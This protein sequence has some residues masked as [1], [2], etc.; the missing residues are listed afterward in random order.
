M[1]DRRANG[2]EWT[3][4][5]RHS[6]GLAWRAVLIDRESLGE[7]LGLSDQALDLISVRHS[8]RAKRL[9]FK[10]SVRGGFELVLPRRY[11]DDW[12]LEA[13]AKR[14]SMV[15]RRLSEIKADRSRLLPQWVT[16]PAVC[17]SWSVSYEMS[18]NASPSVRETPRDTL[19]VAA[20]GR[21][22]FSAALALQGWLQVKAVA[23]L[24][25]LLKETANT[26]GLSYKRVTVRRQKTRWGS[27]SAK[28]NI[29]LNRNLLFMPSHILDYVLHHELVHL[30][31]LDHSFG[32]WDEL[33]NV[34]PGATSCRTELRA[35][36]DS[37]VPV[38]ANV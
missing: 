28:R 31:V 5:A 24:P 21:D 20:D 16:L 2:R 35:L 9:I 13:V 8:S 27:C 38:W 26:L 36:E 29:N 7:L 15:R 14:K 18:E 4:D 17:E 1:R 32:F 11:D 34:L 19:E 3:E 33:E 23:A 22:V 10:S 25:A 6:A 37:A 30:R 12:V